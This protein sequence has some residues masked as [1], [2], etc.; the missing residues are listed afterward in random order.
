MKQLSNS[1]ISNQAGVH[2]G[3]RDIVKKYFA[4]VDRKPFS[5]HT[6][7]AFERVQQSILVD[8]KPL[9]LDACCGVGESSHA[10]AAQYPDHW[11][12]GV[13]KSENRLNRGLN[14]PYEERGNL[15]MVRADLNDFY[16]LAQNAGWRLRRHYIL[17]PNPW[18]KSAHLMR[19]WHGA[20]V[21]PSLVGLG[22]R[23]ELR[24]NW[25][26]YLEEFAE[27]LDV[28]GYQSAITTLSIKDG[29]FLTPFERKYYKSDQALYSLVSHLDQKEP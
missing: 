1:I 17:Y 28:A 5:K 29:F 20:P 25:P 6:L 26:L 19:R 15:L 24:S 4:A 13:D 3:L 23:L 8:P 27:A 21:F 22:G 7:D 16:R 10:L 12:I 2:P 14:H 9:I 18:P 11:V